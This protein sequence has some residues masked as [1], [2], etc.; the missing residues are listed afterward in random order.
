MQC[1]EESLLNM[2][3]L[4]GQVIVENKVQFEVRNRFLQN[5]RNYASK[6]V[7]YLN[8]YFISTMTKKTYVFEQK[9]KYARIYEKLNI[10]IL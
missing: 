8:V 10:F 5:I 7:T 9:L 1:L 3:E 2:F 6:V 4:E